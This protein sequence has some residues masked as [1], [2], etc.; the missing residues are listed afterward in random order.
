ML[1]ECSCYPETRVAKQFL[2]RTEV[3]HEFLFAVSL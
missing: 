3:M 1:Q 2:D